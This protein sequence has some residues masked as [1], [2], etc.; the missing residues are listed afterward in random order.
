[1]SKRQNGEGT[2]NKGGYWMKST[3]GRQQYAHIMMAESAIGKKLPAGAQVH[4]VDGNPSN[5]DP[6][7]LV[8]CPDQKYHRLLHRRTDAL[9]ASGKPNYIIC[10]HCRNYD[11]P[12]KMRR[13]GP[14]SYGHRDCIN[15]YKR[16][17]W[18]ARKGKQ[19]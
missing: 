16:Q 9:I 12:E 15:A 10:R 3:N 13:N 18:A 7:N 2:Y 8:V 1:M 5:N 19:S 17:A 11:D 6:S 14:R 4:H